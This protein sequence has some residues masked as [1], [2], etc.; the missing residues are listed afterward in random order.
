MKEN[1]SIASIQPKFGT[2]NDWTGGLL[3]Q[4]WGTFAGISEHWYDR[5]EKRPEAPPAD[6]LMEFVRSPS[7]Q[8]RMKAEEWL[9]YQQRFPAI[10]QQHIFLSIDE[11]AYMGNSLG[12][13]PTLKQSLAYSMVLQEM[14]RHT[15]FLTMGAFTTGV[16]TMDV[17]P[18]ASVLNATGKVFELYG[19]R[20]G[21]GTIPVA[22]AGD[23]P[24]PE[25]RYPVGFAHPQVRAGSPTY[26]LDIIAGLTADRQHLRIAV[27]NATFNPQ[28]VSIA[29]RGIRTH[30]PGK[31]W[32]LG[33]GRLDSTNRV[34]QPLQ[35]EIAER[36]AA[37]FQGH[38]TL[39]PASV[40]IYDF[41]CTLD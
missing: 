20:F 38:L 4:A 1:A 30:G 40:M 28:P 22:V 8:V 17:T 13:P 39:P 27:V 14:L 29:L 7:N 31:A 36:P 41:P 15:D 12:A 2:E 9:I 6:E 32:R 16:S 10:K 33:N 23:S 3:A 24:Q 26:P 25:P 37:P 34:G 11:Y 21:A 18:T 5:A 19:E 35:V